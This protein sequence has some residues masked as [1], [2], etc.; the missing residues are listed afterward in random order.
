MYAFIF[1]ADNQTGLVRIRVDGEL[2]E[3]S[4]HQL[5]I[6]AKQCARELQRSVDAL[7]AMRWIRVER[8]PR[9]AHRIF[10]TDEHVCVREVLRTDVPQPPDQQS[11]KD[12]Q[13]AD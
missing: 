6:A 5:Q 4:L 10:V 2:V 3:P 13:S 11:A 8:R 7:E 9:K 1:H 12:H